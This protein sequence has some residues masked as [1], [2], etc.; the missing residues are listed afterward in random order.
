MAPQ[1]NGTMRRLL[2]APVWLYRFRCGCLL[3]YRFLLLIHKGRRT[4]MQRYT[5]LEVMEFRDADCEAVVMS[6]WGRN[7][8][9]LC[10]IEETPDCP[11]IVIGSKRFTATYRILGVD[12][13]F[14]VIAGYEQ[15][16]RLIAPVIRAGLSWLFG[17][18]YDGSEQACRRAATQ[19]PYIAFRPLRPSAT[20]SLK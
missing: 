1:L 5:V 4:G 16:N 11:Q 3:G 8:D 2:R 18:R 20:L 9:W 19:V 6:A 13:A 12:E 10:N 15:R 14:K 17:W 7:A